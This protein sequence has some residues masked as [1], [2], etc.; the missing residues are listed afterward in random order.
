MTAAQEAG[1]PGGGTVTAPGEAQFNREY[2][3]NAQRKRR[4]AKVALGLCAHCGREPHRPGRQT[5]DECGR[6]NT[7]RTKSRK[8]SAAHEFLSITRIADV[9]DLANGF[10]PERLRE[11]ARRALQRTRSE[12]EAGQ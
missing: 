8:R 7:A 11:R 12:G 4:A 6:K 1:G 10:V 3:R 9:Q 2:N 5:C